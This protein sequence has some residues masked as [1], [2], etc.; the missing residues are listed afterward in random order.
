MAE[1]SNAWCYVSV[2]EALSYG[3]LCLAMA[4]LT[5]L[6]GDSVLL[7]SSLFDPI[8][9]GSIGLALSV[10]AWLAGSF[11]DLWDGR[12]TDPRPVLSRHVLPMC[13]LHC[14][15][16]ICYSFVCLVMSL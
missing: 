7:V 10:Y 16:V 5:H 3:L 2:L 4:Y 14:K 12:W 9:N 6:M 15:F 11:K 8:I 13:Q 1:L